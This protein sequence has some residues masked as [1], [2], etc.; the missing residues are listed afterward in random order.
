MDTRLTGL[1]A[2][3][4][5]LLSGGAFAADLQAHD[6][7]YDVPGQH[8]SDTDAAYQN[9]AAPAVG[10]DR[11]ARDS[12]YD[13]PGQHDS[14]TDAA[15][16]NGAPQMRIASNDSARY[17]SYRPYGHAASG[18]A[19]IDAHHVLI[20]GRQTSDGMPEINHAGSPGDDPAS[21]T[22]SGMSKDTGYPATSPEPVPDNR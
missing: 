22:A 8:D 4:L 3:A 21:G 2:A 15:Y 19:M 17:D 10:D 20:P 7:G 13:V 1:S 6:T 18:T 14:D 9:R 16:L 11:Q 12:G 5:L